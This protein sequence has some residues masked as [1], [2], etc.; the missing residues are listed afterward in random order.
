MSKSVKFEREV[1]IPPGKFAVNPSIKL[2]EE[3]WSEVFP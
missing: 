1:V 3:L 2:S